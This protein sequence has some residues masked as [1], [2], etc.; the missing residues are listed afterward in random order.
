ME[1]TTE[2]QRAEVV[3]RFEAGENVFDLAMLLIH[4]PATIEDLSDTGIIRQ[5][6]IEDAIRAELARRTERI[7]QAVSIIG[8]YGGIDGGHHKQWILD[9]VVRVLVGGAYSEWVR[10]QESGE[11]GPDTYEWDEG[12]AP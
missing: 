6:A 10:N 11:C 7:Q 4:T 9:Q 12:I 3:R 2:Q 8:Q 5:G 1:L